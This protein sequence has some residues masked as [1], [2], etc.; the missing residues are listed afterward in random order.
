MNQ[1]DSA[2]TCMVTNVIY[3]NSNPAS[4]YLT[5]VRPHLKPDVVVE[6]MTKHKADVHAENRAR[7]L[8][9]EAAALKE[10]QGGE[11]AVD[12]E[13]QV[14]KR[15][16][17]N[18]KQNNSLNG[19]APKKKRTKPP[20]KPHRTFTPGLPYLAWPKGSTSD[21]TADNVRVKWEAVAIHNHLI[22][23]YGDDEAAN[24]M[25]YLTA[26]TTYLAALGHMRDKWDAGL[27]AY[28][29]APKK[30]L[31]AGLI[32]YWNEKPALLGP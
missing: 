28:T 15:R 30:A 6:H 31:R 12:A 4:L 14:L 3:S 5:F 11:D 27:P 22:R 29:S 17:D 16:A 2:L 25:D 8:H 20:T 21:T 24:K 9:K 19:S 13:C 32:A 26:P 1:A 10:S 23:L 18:L 7:T